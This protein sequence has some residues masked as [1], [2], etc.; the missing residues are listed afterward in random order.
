MICSLVPRPLP[1]RR[2]RV[3]GRGL[4][5]RLDDF[6]LITFLLSRCMAMVIFL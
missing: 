1:P 2:V 3:K 4:G 5:I 6:V